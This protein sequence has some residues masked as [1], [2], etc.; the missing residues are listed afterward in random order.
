MDR[1]CWQRDCK[2][3]LQ[4]RSG[5]PSNE[6]LVL[7]NRL[8][9]DLAQ[10]AAAYR[11]DSLYL[12]G[13]AEMPSLREMLVWVYCTLKS[14][15]TGALQDYKDFDEDRHIAPTMKRIIHSDFKFE[16]DRSSIAEWILWLAGMLR[17][18]DA[19]L[20]EVKFVAPKRQAE[21]GRKSRHNWEVE[22]YDC[23]VV[24]IDR[25][26]RAKLN[27]PFVRRGLKFHAI[28]PLRIG[29]DNVEL[30]HH[31]HLKSPGRLRS[32]RP[33]RY[34]AG[35]FPG[36]SV[37]VSYQECG[38]F[39]V[40]SV[41]CQGI[42]TLIDLQIDRAREER[43]DVL[44]WPELTMPE[45]S[46]RQI[47][48]RLISEALSSARK[49]ALV[50]PGTFHVMDESDAMHR[51]RAEIFDGRGRSLLS[52]NKRMK[53][54]VKHQ[55]CAASARSPLAEK[56][57]AIKPGTELSILVMEDR[58]VAVAICLDFCE[59]CETPPYQYLD[60]DLVLVTS[61][62]YRNTAEQHREKAR[63]LHTRFEAE[64]FVVQQSPVVLGDAPLPKKEAQGYS[65]VAPYTVRSGEPMDQNEAFRAFGP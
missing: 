7:A 43:C 18:L 48:E 4:R 3:M 34:A 49:I 19:A 54:R 58:L 53:Y 56:A 6:W 1:Q 33:I 21:T 47:K 9:S 38:G 16:G 32:R 65:F 14:A 17:V 63:T 39:L 37:K 20:A 5:L 41:T 29:S 8:G 46:V 57:E 42:E 35:V 13:T 64:V 36:L 55:D 61:M 24:P 22:G 50:L 26:F 31:S 59:D 40:D 2:A 45:D 62:G 52:Y 60:V 51:N 15:P 11:T 28:I 10:G 25:S 30:Y 44:M 12:E 23:Y 27:K